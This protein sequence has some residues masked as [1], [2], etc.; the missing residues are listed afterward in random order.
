MKTKIN[1]DLSEDVSM[2]RMT[3]I[4]RLT[5][6]FMELFPEHPASEIQLFRTADDAVSVEV[7][8][9]RKRNIKVNVY[10]PITLKSLGVAQVAS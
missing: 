8:W 7:W 6:L 9:T 1:F 2:D 10:K 4:K 3:E 5:A